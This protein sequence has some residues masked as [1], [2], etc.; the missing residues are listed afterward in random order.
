MNMNIGKNIILTL[1]GSSHGEFV[2]GIMKNFPKD[3]AVDFDLIAKDLQ[4]RK[5]QAYGTPR[6][7]D[8]MPVFLSGITNGKTDGGE[9]I[10][11]VKNKNVRVQDYDD[12]CGYFRPSHADYPYY[13]KYGEDK[14]ADKD[15]ASARMFLPVVIAGCFCKMFLRQQGISVQAQVVEVGGIDY[16]NSRSAAEEL[17][18]AIAKQ[19]DTLGGM[20]KCEVTGVNAGVGEP[21]FDKISANLAKAVMSIPSAVSFSLGDTLN[22]HNL[23]GSEDIDTWSSDFTTKTNH[24]GGI[25]AG[26]TNGMPVVFFAGFHAVHTLHKEMT[27]IGEKGDLLTRQINGR[28]DICAVLRTPV[29]VESVAALTISDCML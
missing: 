28:H 7:E 10:F 19:G 2:C 22:R 11:Q 4:R 26:I 18:S 23:K 13:I 8:D 21:V 29:I 27:L 17:L 24:C 1:T 6:K 20:I 3:I 15:T 9:I 25:N 14:L 12:F 5:P 16:I